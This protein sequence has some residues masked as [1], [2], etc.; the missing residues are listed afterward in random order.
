MALI[1]SSSRTSSNQNIRTED[2]RVS[3]DGSVVAQFREIEGDVNFID[4][5]AIALGEAGLDLA[6]N[7]AAGA[8]ATA[9]QAGSGAGAL[10][11]QDLIK[12][13]VPVVIIAIIVWGVTR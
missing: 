4:P 2:N 1:G 9:Q 8:L 10:I 7:I 3:A 11:A 5:G 13:A 12:S 6:G